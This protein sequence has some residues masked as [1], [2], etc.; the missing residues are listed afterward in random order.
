MRLLFALLPLLL[1]PLS[2]CAAPPPLMLASDYHDGIRI[3]EYLVSEKLDGVRGHWDGRTLWTRGGNRIHAPEW[4]TAGWPALAMDGELWIARGRFDDVSGIVRTRGG[5]HA[6][7]REVHFM[8]FDLPAHEG[9]FSQRAQAMRTLLASVDIAW[10]QPVE[11]RQVND[12]PALQAWLRAVVAAGGEGLMLHHRD[13]RYR[14][15]R[16]SDLLKLKPFQ[17]AEATVIGHTRGRGKYTGMTGALIVQRPDGLRLRIGSGLTDAQRASPPPVGSHVT[18][19]YN[20][21]TS[22]GVPRFARFLRMR[23][24]LPPPDPE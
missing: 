6:G 1:L 7:W 11:Q 15:G 10:L 19:R 22:K 13:G 16:S 23:D 21:L 20:G 12:K 17:D 5:D 18:Y 3:T 9:G 4:F 14:A 8:A 24:E 2:A